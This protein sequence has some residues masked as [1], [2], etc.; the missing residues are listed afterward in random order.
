MGDSPCRGCSQREL[1]CKSTCDEWLVYNVLKQP[2]RERVEQE[3]RKRTL[4]ESDRA[5]RI[6][7]TKHVKRSEES[8]TRCRKR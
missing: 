4:V 6:E 2:E 3:R 8:P 7:R 5:Y 1:G